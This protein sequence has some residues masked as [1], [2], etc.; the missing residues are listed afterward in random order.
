MSAILF[1]KRCSA[2]LKFEE[3]KYWG[4]QETCAA[5]ELEFD[6]NARRMGFG[7]KNWNGNKY[8]ERKKGG[9]YFIVIRLGK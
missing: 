8:R 9:V 4:A 2:S 5:A 3:H 7:N 1:G 6:E